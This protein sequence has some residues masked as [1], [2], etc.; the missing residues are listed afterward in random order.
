MP[1]FT[2]MVREAGRLLG[3]TEVTLPEL[4]FVPDTAVTH[5]DADD[6]ETRF[7]GWGGRL[8]VAMHEP[9]DESGARRPLSPESFARQANEAVDGNPFASR[10]IRN[11]FKPDRLFQ[12]LAV[13]ANASR[14]AVMEAR[15]AEVRSAARDLAV[16]EGVVHRAVRDPVHF[17]SVDRASVRVDTRID[18]GVQGAP[19]I[20][21]NV[22]RADRGRDAE[23]FAAELAA[24]RGLP[25]GEPSGWLRV[26]YSQI[27]K[28]DDVGEAFAEAFGRFRRL[29]LHDGSGLGER[30]ASLP[31]DLAD[32]GSAE[33]AYAVLGKVRE[34]LYR[35][36]DLKGDMRH[37]AAVE[38]CDL[39]AIRYE[40]VDRDWLTA[41]T[42]V[43][44]FA[45]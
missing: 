36:R 45:P 6:L 15:L 23:I 30:I 9:A 39:V 26:V 37:E 2:L 43:P 24:S 25:L 18:D 29:G 33:E 12:P 38:V 41:R 44:V 7:L 10:T 40:S 5:V 34:A 22:F 20:V 11:P 31:R 8:W 13:P 19:R 21:W 3:E 32:P 14:T 42:A 27:L 17:V 16:I 1:T 28:V 35:S 4:T